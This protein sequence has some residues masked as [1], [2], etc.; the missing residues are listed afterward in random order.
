[1]QLASLS[2]WGCNFLFLA[3]FMNF[4][5]TVPPHFSWFSLILYVSWTMV[6]CIGSYGPLLLL[7]AREREKQEHQSIP[8]FLWNKAILSS[9]GNGVSSSLVNTAL[10]GQAE[11][12][13]SLII[14]PVLSCPINSSDWF[15]CFQRNC[16]KERLCNH[17]YTV[18]STRALNSKE[19]AVGLSFSSES[20]QSSTWSV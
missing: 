11:R 12:R 16:Q 6:T 20:Y 15:L 4:I 14:L 18:F 19:L 17:L 2:F 7:K 5:F 10:S 9:C 3:L 13:T 1:M 8:Y